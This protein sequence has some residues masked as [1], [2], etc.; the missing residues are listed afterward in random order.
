VGIAESF[1]SRSQERLSPSS[2]AQES[3]IQ[4]ASKRFGNGADE[5]SAGLRVLVAVSSTIT[6]ARGCKSIEAV[7]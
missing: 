6:S 1:F 7:G 2:P 4:L 3:R 5:S